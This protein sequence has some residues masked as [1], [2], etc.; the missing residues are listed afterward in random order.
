MLPSICMHARRW[1]AKQS[2]LGFKC[3]MRD[4]SM[5]MTSQ[6]RPPKRVRTDGMELRL[7]DKVEIMLSC[8]IVAEAMELLKRVNSERHIALSYS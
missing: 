1:S 7:L 6:S 2:L 3:Q 4:V 5:P 8:F